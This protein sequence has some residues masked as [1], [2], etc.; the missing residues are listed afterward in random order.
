[1]LP[2]DKTLY[3]DN[4]LNVNWKHAPYQTE[5]EYYPPT[6]EDTTLPDTTHNFMQL[7]CELRCIAD[8]IIPDIIYAVIL[9]LDAFDNPTVFNWRIFTS[10]LRYLTNPLNYG[11]CFQKR[12]ANGYFEASLKTGL[13]VATS[14]SYWGNDKTDR[15]SITKL[16]FNYNNVPMH[17]K[18]KKPNSIALS[19]KKAEYRAMTD[20]LQFSIHT[21]TLTKSFNDIVPIIIYNDNMPTLDMLKALEAT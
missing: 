14:E 7:V 9:L 4:M 8:C 5:T 1:M 21:Q 15:K 17:W 6:D 13:I 11:L 19:T 16:F 2:I 12:N 3:D 18:S 20:I 10:T